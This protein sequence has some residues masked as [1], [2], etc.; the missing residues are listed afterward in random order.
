M[1]MMI[2]MIV[3]ISM[4]LLMIWDDLNDSDDPAYCDDAV[5][6]GADNNFSYLDAGIIT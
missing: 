1:I 5:V 6:V 3:M 2:M 4:V